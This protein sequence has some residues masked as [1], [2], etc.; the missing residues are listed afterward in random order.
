M[1]NLILSFIKLELKKNN[2]KLAVNLNRSE[3]VDYFIR[4]NQIHLKSID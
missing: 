2:L 3:G 4:D 1:N